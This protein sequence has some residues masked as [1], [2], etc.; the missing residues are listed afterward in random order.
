MIDGICIITLSG[1]R[2]IFLGL[3]SGLFSGLTFSLFLSADSLLFLLTLTFFLFYTLLFSFLYFLD[4]FLLFADFLNITEEI[5]VLQTDFIAELID[6]SL[7]MA[8][9]SSI[10]PCS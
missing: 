2:R 8:I 3:F 5:F 10:V 4:G 7:L 9:S 1:F 6:S